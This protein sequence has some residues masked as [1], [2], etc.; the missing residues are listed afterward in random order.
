MAKTNSNAA[1][2][3]TEM[4]TAAAVGETVPAPAPALGTQV[5]V[6]VAQ[7]CL[8]INNE[9]GAYFAADTATPVM[10]NTTL[11]RRLADGDV[12]L[13]DTPV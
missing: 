9:T 5:H 6:K 10:V 13:V 4:T 8:L 3:V 12:V 2:A 1:P 11:L 7:G